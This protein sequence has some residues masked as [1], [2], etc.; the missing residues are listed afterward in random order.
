MEKLTHQE[1]EMMLIIFQQGKGFI[2]DFITVPND[3]VFQLELFKETAKFTAEE[4]LERLKTGK[5]LR[6]ACFV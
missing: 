4:L 1:Q 3:T 5:F 6:I 2:K